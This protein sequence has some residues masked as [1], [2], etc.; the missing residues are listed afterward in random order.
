MAWSPYK[1]SSNELHTD[2]L[3]A[4]GEMTKDKKGIT[5]PSYRRRSDPQNRFFQIHQITPLMISGAF[6]CPLPLLKRAWQREGA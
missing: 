6:L 5:P 4:V 2:V 3:P 1:A